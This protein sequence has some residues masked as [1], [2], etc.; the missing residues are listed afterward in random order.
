MCLSRI[1]LI[2]WLESAVFT[3]E[4]V[5]ALKS[6]AL[7]KDSIANSDETWCRIRVNGACLKKYL[8]CLVNKSV[9]ILIYFYKDRSRGCGVLNNFPDKAEVGNP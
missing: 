4:L 5:E 1:T 9:R 8:W 7:E 2:S 6:V 3:K